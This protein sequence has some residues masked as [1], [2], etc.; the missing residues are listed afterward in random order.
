MEILIII[1]VVIGGW[2]LFKV[3]I[4]GIQMTREQMKD[5]GDAGRYVKSDHPIVRD[6]V[7]KSRFKN[8]VNKYKKKGYSEAEAEQLAEQEFEKNPGYINPY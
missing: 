8:C 4:P 6:A 5:I 1:L 7:A 3:V 2:V